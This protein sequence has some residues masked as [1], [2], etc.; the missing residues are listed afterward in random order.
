MRLIKTLLLVVVLLA[1]INSTQQVSRG[2]KMTQLLSKS[3]L[4]EKGWF[5]DAWNWTKKAVSTATSWVV[6][7]AKDVGS[8]I[9]SAASTVANW[10]VSAAKAAVQGIKDAA[11]AL[12]ITAIG[13]QQINQRCLLSLN[14]GYQLNCA[15]TVCAPN[16]GWMGA[17][18]VWNQLVCNLKSVGALIDALKALFKNNGDAKD[19]FLTFFKTPLKCLLERTSN[20]YGGH[21]KSLALSTSVSSGV[22]LTTA[23]AIGFAAD[24]KGDANLFIQTC[25]G[26]MVSVG[27][28]VGLSLTLS[29]SN[30]SRGGE[31]WDANAGID[32]GIGIGFSYSYDLSKG[33]YRPELASMS[34]YASVGVSVG[35]DV[36]L[37]K[38]RSEVLYDGFRIW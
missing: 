1:L 2:H 6:N 30:P 21:F 4:R 26:F 29:T 18:M 23:T 12:H 24:N 11:A 9:A 19:K 27:S 14:C 25:N 13:T 31:W 20:E 28:S 34:F 32:V 7:K 5:S 3:Q 37:M 15:L 35:F 10:T 16:V 22:G 38:C 33:W 17:K 8:A 36:G